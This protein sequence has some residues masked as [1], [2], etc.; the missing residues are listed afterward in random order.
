M[1]VAFCYN[2]VNLRLI[3][4][5]LRRRYELQGAASTEGR[6]SMPE[7][8]KVSSGKLQREAPRAQIGSNGV[9]LA[10]NPVGGATGGVAN[11]E[12]MGN[13]WEK[14]LTH[15]GLQRMTAENQNRL[16]PRRTPRTAAAARRKLLIPGF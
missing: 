6:H 8:R 11:P 15:R 7:G 13:V 5:K 2:Y 10:D 4:H 12:W 16:Q 9:E 3:S 14:A 1:L